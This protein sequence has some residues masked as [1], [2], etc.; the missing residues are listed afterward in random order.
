MQMQMDSPPLDDLRNLFGSLVSQALRLWRRAVDTRLEPFGLTEASWLPLL[1]ISRASGPVRQKDLAAALFVDSS[2]LVR[3]IDELE[4]AGL[5]RRKDAEDDRRAKILVLTVKGRKMVARVEEAVAE[6]RGR[7][8]SNI[9]DGELRMASSVLTRIGET[10][11]AG[12]P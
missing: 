10:L 3:V 9:P 4:R 12:S 1:H 8:L 6:V 5:L 7:I 11:K 2:S